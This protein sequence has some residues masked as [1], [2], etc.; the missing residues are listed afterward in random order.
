M[1][2]YSIQSDAMFSF[3]AIQLT[4]LKLID[5][6][7]AIL[8]LPNSVAVH[9]IYLHMANHE[10]NMSYC[11]PMVDCCRFQ[12][13][14][15]TGRYFVSK[16]LTVRKHARPRL[17]SDFDKICRIYCG[18]IFQTTLISWVLCPLIKFRSSLG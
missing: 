9:Q 5:Q 1:L 14:F 16:Y 13:S 12:N 8:W 18:P 10:L 2:A 4:V 17:D 7:L 11:P 3:S 15:I 6:L